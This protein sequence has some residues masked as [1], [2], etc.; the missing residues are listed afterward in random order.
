M[1]RIERYDVYGKWA[2]SGVVR[3]GN[4]VFLNCCAGNVGQGIFLKHTLIPETR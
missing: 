4:L 1:S 2:H 3:A